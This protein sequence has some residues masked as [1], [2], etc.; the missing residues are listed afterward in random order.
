MAVLGWG[1]GCIGQGGW[2]Y[3]GGVLAVV[4]RG[5]AVVGR[6]R[7]WLNWGGGGCITIGEGLAVLREGCT[8]AAPTHSDECSY[9]LLDQVC[10]SPLAGV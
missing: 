10:V 4:G 2:L 3:W 5:L 7:G 9:V 8:H 6:G 1:V